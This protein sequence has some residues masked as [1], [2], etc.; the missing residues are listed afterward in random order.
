MAVSSRSAIQTKSVRRR[1]QEQTPF[2]QA[3]RLFKEA[4]V[5]V[6]AYKDFLRKA[7]I[8]PDN[9]ET[10]GDFAHIPPTDKPNYI[11]AYSLAELSWDGVLRDVKFIS[12]SSGSTGV[13]FY[14]PRG[15]EQHV[16]SG[17]MFRRLYET[18]FHTKRG[19][20]L[21][22]DLF[23]LGQW[24]A[25]LEFY[26]ATKYVADRGSLI[27][28]ATPSFEKTAALGTLCRLAPLYDRIILSGYPPFI[29]D[30][31]ESGLADGIRFKNLDLRLFVAGEAISELWRDRVLSLIGA[32]D[33]T[34]IINLYG[35]A[36]TGAVGHETPLSITLR[37][38]APRLPTV[39]DLLSYDGM[40]AA[41]YQYDPT[42][43][44]L[45][46]GENSTIMMT[47]RAGLPLVRYNTRDQGG[48]LSYSDALA[49]IKKGGVRER[50]EDWQLPLVYLFGRRDLS[51]SLY[52]FNVYV[53]NIKHCLERYPRPKE[54]SGLF[55]MRVEHDESF[56]QQFEIAVELA[57][58]VSPTRK[59][60]HELAEHIARTLRTVNSEYNKTYDSLGKRV[61]PHVTL[62]PY[63]AMD[64][65]PGRKHRW[66][67]RA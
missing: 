6:P 32:K 12:S 59:S 65:L 35:M 60:A 30:V 25:G 19:S 8:N 39:R 37:R 47:A 41:L 42:V 50:F 20:T 67:K 26:N 57:R 51:L 23:A 49:H 18:T 1:A 45:E 63:G 34:R 27:S 62:I 64:T 7:K 17:E 14:W 9:I 5:R 13:P 21:F 58:G 2:A 66:V 33:P 55:S 56:D 44:Y 36:E 11:N 53:E 43:R 61:H 40:T 3:L 15:E 22:C 38:L 31:I 46:V 48:L 4:A 24:I 29:K 54:L 10:P 52:A 28:I 16:A